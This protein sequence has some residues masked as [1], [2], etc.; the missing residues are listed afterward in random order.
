MSNIENKI[1]SLLKPNNRLV[2]RCPI[3][4][5]GSLSTI[6]GGSHGLGDVVEALLSLEED[7]VVV[8]VETERNIAP[9]VWEPKTEFYLVVTYPN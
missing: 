7:G 6:N 4:L 5:W 1:I 8:R 2:G 3:Q 9:G